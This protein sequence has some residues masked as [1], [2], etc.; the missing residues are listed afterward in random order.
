MCYST[1]V[2][3]KGQLCGDG[4]LLHLCGFQGWSSYQAWME[5][6]QLAQGLFLLPASL[7]PLKCP[8]P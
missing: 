3:V 2:E 1:C 8:G 6:S 7:I 4:S 5:A